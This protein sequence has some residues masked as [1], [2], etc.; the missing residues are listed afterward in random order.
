MG[1]IAAA[2]VLIVFSKKRRK[3]LNSQQEFK[4]YLNFNK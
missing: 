2:L 4:I 1:Y 3:Y